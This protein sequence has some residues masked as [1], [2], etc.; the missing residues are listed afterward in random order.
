MERINGI[1]EKNNKRIRDFSKKKT[2]IKIVSAAP[3]IYN[4][5]EERAANKSAEQNKANRI[6]VS[7]VDEN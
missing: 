3:P 7:T 4:I 6:D 2:P 1:E 5:W